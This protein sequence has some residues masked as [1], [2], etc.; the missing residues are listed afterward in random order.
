MG[1][2]PSRAHPWRGRYRQ[3]A[4]E[5]PGTKTCT[6]CGV[7]KPPEAFHRDR[8]R[9]RSI[10]AD[11]TTARFRADYTANPDRYRA[12]RETRREYQADYWRHRRRR[13]QVPPPHRY[14][15]IERAEVELEV[16]HDVALRYARVGALRRVV[17]LRRVYVDPADVAA[18]KAR[19][20]NGDRSLNHWKQ[21]PRQEEAA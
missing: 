9:R 18:V 20:E 7:T 10:C 8:D 5:A 14:W 3:K 6:R 15:P 17:Y 21:T 4:E 19:R 1:K 16:S 11:C 12:Y 13:K 2:I